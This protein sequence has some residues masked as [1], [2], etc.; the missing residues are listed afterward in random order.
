MRGRES[1][2]GGGEGPCVPGGRGVRGGRARD[3]EQGRKASPGGRITTFLLTDLER[4]LSLL[5]P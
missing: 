2:P 1:A 3:G 5:Q 4:E